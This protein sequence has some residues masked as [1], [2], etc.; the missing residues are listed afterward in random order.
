MREPNFKKNRNLKKL[1]IE[2]VRHD[3]RPNFEKIETKNTI[4]YESY[5]MTI[6]KFHDYFYSELLFILIDFVFI[7]I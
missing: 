2:K 6:K 3:Q 5:W 7:S 1:R 4:K